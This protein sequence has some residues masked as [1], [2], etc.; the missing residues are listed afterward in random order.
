MIEQ[1]SLHT[2]RKN[3]KTTINQRIGAVTRFYAYQFEQ[4]RIKKLPFTSLDRNSARS[5]DSSALAHTSSSTTTSTDLTLNSHTLLPKFL[6][7]SDART[8][9]KA[10]KPGRPRLQGVLM[11]LTGMR[12]EEV[13]LMT[14]DMIIEL[15][16]EANKRVQGELVPLK[17]PA[18]IAKGKKSRTVYVTK[19]FAGKLRQY[20]ILQRPKLAKKF[21]KKNGRDSNRLWLSH[22][23]KE[24]SVRNLNAV[25]T[26]AS[27]KTG[28]YCTPHMLRHTFATHFF[29]RTG[30]L[31]TLQKLMGHSHISTTTIYEHSSTEDRLGFMEQY[32][33]EIDDLLI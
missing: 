23:G 22:W 7:L 8:F 11:N 33:Q 20:R 13:A 9:I 14:I 3:S 27:K 29:E 17:I 30:D 5:K 4:G 12:R 2:G 26:E 25:F 18:E 19:N 1:V 28:I 31:R 21:K 32:Q 6:S 16:T 24:L 10:L 15:E